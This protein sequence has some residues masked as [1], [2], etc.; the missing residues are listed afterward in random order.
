VTLTPG[1][2]LQ[3]SSR[4]QEAP[5][6]VLGG[7]LVGLGMA[8]TV[9]LAQR[10][11]AQDAA[12]DEIPQ[13]LPP[14]GEIPPGIWEQHSAAIVIG[15]ILLLAL[16]AV[17]V[18]FLR[19]PKT[20]L[21][22]DP[23]VQARQELSSLRGQP[24]TGALLSRISG[25]VRRYTAAAFSLPPGELTTAEFSRAVAGNEAVGSALAESVT[26]FLKRCD[27]RKFA[28]PMV[29]PPI[30]AADEAMRLVEVAEARRE[31]LRKAA[32]QSKAAATD[33]ASP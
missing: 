2:L 14:R 6:V 22:V 27:E 23:E 20:I 26:D 29:R 12:A 33:T 25:S 16:G 1:I 21:P 4:R 9:F 3:R 30:G 13:L 11:W 31:E 17:L 7:R 8:L 19:R 28:P 5:I 18:W 24:E 32:A 15:G 10:A